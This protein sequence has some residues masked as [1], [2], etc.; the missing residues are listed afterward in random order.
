MESIISRISSGISKQRIFLD[1]IVIHL[2]KVVHPHPFCTNLD[3]P[4]HLDMI[5]LQKALFSLLHPQ[6][7]H[8][9][10]DIL[11]AD[12]QDALQTYLCQYVL[13]KQ[14]AFLL[15]LQHGLNQVCTFFQYA[16]HK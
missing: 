4:I 10:T 3:E 8:E 1:G 9:N 16:T 14:H 5:A 6:Y 13:M 2:N 11:K 15:K 12:I 7:I